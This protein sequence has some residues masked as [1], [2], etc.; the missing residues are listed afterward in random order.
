MSLCFLT[1]TDTPLV[2]H[3]SNI[4]PKRHAVAYNSIYLQWC[5]CYCKRD[6]RKSIMRSVGGTHEIFAVLI[7]RKKKDFTEA[8]N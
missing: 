3:G 2:V 8:D 1:R 5:P 4:F 7:G 6:V